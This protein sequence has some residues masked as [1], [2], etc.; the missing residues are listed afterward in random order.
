MK[1]SRFIFHKVLLILIHTKTSY[2]SEYHPT[3]RSISQTLCSCNTNN[4]TK[5]MTNKCI[6][7]YPCSHTFTT[8]NPLAYS[9][10][11]LFCHL[12]TLRKAD[13]VNCVD[14]FLQNVL[15]LLF[16]NQHITQNI[17]SYSLLF[18]NNFIEIYLQFYTSNFRYTLFTL[19]STGKSYFGIPKIDFGIPIFLSVY[20]ENLYQHWENLSGIPSI[21]IFSISYNRNE[22]NIYKKV[23]I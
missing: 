15:S 17:L 6:S 3:H 2:T 13:F 8:A 10:T 11:Q 23:L 4:H 7:L 18:V 12:G 20:H 5:S 19:T 22:I 1:A 21:P 14:H 16:S 9:C